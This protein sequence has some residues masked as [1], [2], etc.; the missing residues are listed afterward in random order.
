[1]RDLI[2]TAL[3]V[4]SLPF[5]FIYPWIGVLMWSWIGYM[6]PHRLSWGFAYDF[7]FAQMIAIAT[8][9]GLPF[10][11]SR[12]ALPWT[13]PLV[14]LAC[15]WLLFLLS[16]S[17]AAI[18]PVAAWPQLTTVSKILLM[19]FLTVVLFQD[20]QRL[21]VLIAVIAL[22]IGFHGAKAGMWAVLTGTT[23]RVVGPPGTFIADNNDLALALNMVL[24]LLFFL[25]GEERRRWLRLFFLAIFLLSILGVLL[26]YS[27]GGFLGLAIVLLALMV[28]RGLKPQFVVAA[29]IVGLGMYATLPEQW[30]QRMDSIKSYEED[31]SAK[32]RL[33][34]WSVGFGLALDHPIL[35]A[36]FKPFTEASFRRY[37]PNY[38]G[39]HDAHSIIFQMLAE[40]GFTGLFLFLWLIVSCLLALRRITHRTRGPNGEPW[41]LQ[42]AQAV[43]ISFVGYLVSG[44]FLGRAYFDLFYHLVAITVLLDVLTEAQPAL[45]AKAEKRA[46]QQPRR[47]RRSLAT[48]RQKRPLGVAVEDRSR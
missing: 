6:N 42:L 14:L 41:T 20:R 47:A 22:S 16:T 43:Q 3:V 40:N 37:A 18:N 46:L 45:P 4:G 33:T 39:R 35:G 31:A 17:F 12:G 23:N 48:A 44:L 36:G 21:H 30:F 26:T 11:R 24:P 38:G 32:A 9:A 15:L 34:A 19:T 8:L 2:V 1:M 7:P 25:Y 13:T 27:R 10:D 29:A 28:R 5:C